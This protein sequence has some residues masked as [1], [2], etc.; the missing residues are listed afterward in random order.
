MSKINPDINYIRKY[1]NG[2]L[3]HREMFELERAFLEDEMLLDILLGMEHEQLHNYSSDLSDLRQRIHARS[4]LSNNK[5]LFPWKSLSLAASLLLVLSLGGYWIWN[6]GSSTKDTLI[7]Q[8]PEELNV[9]TPLIDKAT[10]TTAGKIEEQ[11]TI[12]QNAIAHSS[13]SKN[14]NLGHTEKQPNKVASSVYTPTKKAAIPNVAFPRQ[15]ALR[16]SP[17]YSVAALKP[18]KAENLIVIQNTPNKEE[19][20]IGRGISDSN[21]EHNIAANIPQ[22]IQG[23]A[24]GVRAPDIG[25]NSSNT[26]NRVALSRLNLDAQ[27]NY[28]LGQVLDMQSG[29]PIE[30]VQIKDMENNN[31]VSTDSAGNFVY[32]AN[33]KNAPL[34][35]NAVGYKKEKIL[36]DNSSQTI[37]LNRH[38]SALGE[39]VVTSAHKT[40]LKSEPVSGWKE[41]KAYINAETKKVNLGKGIVALTFS[42]TAEGRPENILVSKSANL[43]LDKKAIEIVKQGPRWITGNN[44][45]P[46]YLT[47]EF[48]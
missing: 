37:L 3:S 10:D 11:Q 2:E 14:T 18:S 45:K 8:S 20:I 47:V 48:K 34:E 32:L 5:R 6:N 30:N 21:K 16:D 13:D 9:P 35:I 39:V 23:R 43:N 25:T 15:T 17:A 33:R 44:G 22:Q 31:V 1:V 27:S 42:I 41:F 7:A 28:I 38:D 29:N 36:A 12:N 40:P 19:V 46:V 24:E 26:N 4:H